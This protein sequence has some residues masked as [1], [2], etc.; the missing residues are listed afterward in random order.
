MNKLEIFCKIF[1]DKLI[2]KQKFLEIN[3]TTK[4][5]IIGFSIRYVPI[6][7]SIQYN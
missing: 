5:Y 2:E 1:K 3:L 7:E 4:F 6:Q